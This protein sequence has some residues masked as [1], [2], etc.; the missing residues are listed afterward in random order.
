MNTILVGAQWGDEGKGKIVDVLTEEHD[1]VVRSQGGNNAGHTILIGEKKF[2]LHLL[3]TG[4][5]RP[6]KLGIIGNGCVVD[7]I[8]LVNEINGLQE[9]GIKL[10]KRLF[11]SQLAHLVLPYHRYLDA[12]NEDS[13]R[14][15]AKIGTTRRG[16]GPAYGDK[17][18]RTGLRMHDLLDEAALS[19]KLRTRLRQINQMMKNAG[20]KSLPTGQIVEECLAA[21]PVLQPYIADTVELI[22][23]LRVEEKR[24][25]FEGAQGTFLDI[26]F[27]TYPYVTSSNTTSGGACT[28]TGLP[29]TAVDGVVGALKAYTT[30]VGEG[31]FPTESRDLGKRLH[32]MGREFGA[33]TGRARRCGWLDAVMVR[34]A[35]RLNGVTE[36]ALTNL[37]GLDDLDE[38]RM[39]VGYRLGRKRLSSPP[40]DPAAF[41]EL[42]PEYR[43][44]PG[45]QTPTSGCRRL[46]DLPP[47]AR[48]YLNAVE[49]FCEAPLRMISIGPKREETVRL[50]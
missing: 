22:H 17:I 43:S 21:A 35:V 16:I 37:D 48:D 11:L 18:A 26:D 47:R 39:C 29:P 40:A 50:Q 33:T 30:R 27:G 44:F 20:A 38:V 14:G 34:H 41:A 4:L 6:G 7:P 25:L 13:A 2:V 15:K 9:K 12:W 24:L 3:P 46:A 32:G 23:R 42:K 10:R 19:K 36:L 8:G 45:W 28:G 5:L 31:P 49:E 1:A